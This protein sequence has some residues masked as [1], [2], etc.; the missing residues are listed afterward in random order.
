MG[1]AEIG[2]IREARERESCA[3]REQQQE[4][5]RG[6]GRNE[7]RWGRW[8]CRCCTID[9]SD[10]SCL[11]IITGSSDCTSLRSFLYDLIAALALLIRIGRLPFIISSFSSPLST[12]C[13]TC[14]GPAPKPS[15]PACFIP[16][17]LCPSS[18]AASWTLLRSLHWNFGIS[19][20]YLSR[21]FRLCTFLL[22]I[23]G[24]RCSS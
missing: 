19:V 12:T 21:S 5:A 6:E 24:P 7:G 13:T 22:V 9:D 1:H 14:P 18:A 23:G 16:D 11:P 20:R 17:A 15:P 8:W 2:L 3:V 4:R 10:V